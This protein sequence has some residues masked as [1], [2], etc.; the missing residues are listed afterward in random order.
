MLDNRI[1]FSDRGRIQLGGLERSRGRG[2]SAR[3]ID[4]SR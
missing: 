3:D 2:S 1:C 4:T